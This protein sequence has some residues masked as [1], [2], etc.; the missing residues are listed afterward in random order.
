MLIQVGFNVLLEAKL[1]MLQFDY[2]CLDKYID[3]SD[4]QKMYMD[5][6]S[7]YMTISDKFQNLIK[8]ALREEYEID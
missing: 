4:Y 3:R 6:D 7:C 1:R 8:P 5:T 2:D